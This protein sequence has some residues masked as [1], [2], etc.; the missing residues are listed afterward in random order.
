MRQILF[1]YASAL[2]NISVMGYIYFRPV[3]TIHYVDCAFITKCIRSECFLRHCLGMIVLLMVLMEGKQYKNT[4]RVPYSMRIALKLDIVILILSALFLLFNVILVHNLSDTPLVH[5]DLFRVDG[6]KKQSNCVRSKPVYVC[7]NEEDESFSTDDSDDMDTFDN[8]FK[9]SYSLVNLRDPDDCRD[10]AP[11]DAYKPSKISWIWRCLIKIHFNYY[12]TTHRK[13]DGMEPW[14][15]LAME[16]KWE[17]DPLGFWKRKE[18][19]I[20]KRYKKQHIA[21]VEEDMFDKTEMKK[22]PFYKQYEKMNRSN[23]RR[24]RRMPRKFMSHFVSYSWSKLKWN[25]VYMNL[26]REECVNGMNK[27]RKT[28]RIA[29]SPPLQHNMHLRR[30]SAGAMSGGDLMDEDDQEEEKK[31]YSGLKNR[32]EAGHYARIPS[33]SRSVSMSRESCKGK[34]KE[35]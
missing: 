10:Y 5:I 25:S 28:Y 31:W 26:E 11:K 14:S 30:L 33:R 21:I 15:R 9:N 34:T 27:E 3:V 6:R 2:S 20:K 18:K 16:A 23:E 24:R 8:T 7:Y 13:G 17:L 22:N 35:G 12:N 4:E 29:V 1:I 19:H 32:K